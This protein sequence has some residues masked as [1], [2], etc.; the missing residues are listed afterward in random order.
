MTKHERAESASS[1]AERLAKQGRA[2]AKARG[3]HITKRD[4]A[5]AF[6]RPTPNVFPFP[7]TGERVNF[8]APRGYFNPREK[9]F[10]VDV[11]E[12]LAVSANF[13]HVFDGLSNDFSRNLKKL[14]DDLGIEID[15]EI[16]RWK[17]IA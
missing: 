13:P 7:R 12:F 9:K 14:E 4:I 6:T 8:D 17:E 16:I 3:R 11:A 1:P 15:G 5:S 2:S 10:L